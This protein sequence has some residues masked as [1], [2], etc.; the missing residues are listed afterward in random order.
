MFWKPTL[1]VT[2]LKYYLHVTNKE[3]TQTAVYKNKPMKNMAE[4]KRKEEGLTKF[5]FMSDK[6][7]RRR[8]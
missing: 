5:Q 4:F 8:E 1:N 7:L 6:S 3:L 2:K